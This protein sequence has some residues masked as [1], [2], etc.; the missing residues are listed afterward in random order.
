[1]LPGTLRDWIVSWR[2]DRLVP[3]PLG[4]PAERGSADRR[5]EVLKWITGLGGE[6]SVRS[7]KEAFPDMGRA[8]LRDLKRRWRKIARKRPERLLLRLDFTTPGTVWAM[9][10]AQP[11]RKVDGIFPYF[12]AVRDLASGK[13]LAAMP[14]LHDD[15]KSARDV[16]QA[17]FLWLPPPLVLKS[18]NA[19]A[20][21]TDEMRDLL[22]ANGILPLFSP[23]YYP[24]YNG[25]CETGIGTIKT[26][27]HHA[28]A[29]RGYPGEFTAN[30]FHTAVC[31]ANAL[32]RP[33]GHDGLT[34]DE[35]WNEARAVPD[36]LRNYFAERYAIQC[37]KELDRQELATLFDLEPAEK[38]AVDRAAI[39]RAL[40][41]CGFLCVKR[42]RVF[43]PIV[44][45]R[46][47]FLSTT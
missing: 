28:A 45:R 8:E 14:I 30:D 17:L 38:E 35:A 13:H 16:L 7:L 11:E 15:S 18:D 29:D 41:D 39:G 46:L 26:F 10:F 12:F 27:A 47:R 1:M 2:D 42:R 3:E 9:D 36:W 4:R 24:Q 44:Q 33:R 40:M 21:K 22:G 20:F 5:N 23:P 43:P 32:T 19:K 6:V 31:R 34:P 37:R 25:A